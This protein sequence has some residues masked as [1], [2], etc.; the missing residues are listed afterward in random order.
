MSKKKIRARVLAFILTAVMMA[1]T[2]V[3]SGCSRGGGDVSYDGDLDTPFSRGV[4]FSSW[5]ENAS[6]EWIDT[7]RYTEKD[8][9]DAKN[10][11]I[12]IIR[13]PVNFHKF[14]GNAP[15]YTLDAGFMRFLDIVIGWAQKHELY[16]VLDNHSWSPSEPTPADIDDVLIPVWEQVASRYK[17][18]GNFLLFEILNEPWDNSGYGLTSE[19]WMDI[20]RRAV[21]AIRAIDTRRVLVVCG[22]N[23]GIDELEKIP[24]Y[25]DHVYVSLLC[26]VF[27][28]A[29]GRDV[30][31]PAALRQL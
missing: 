21:E 23:D 10:M 22:I 28:S 5:L 31:Y 7:L 29:S 8:F 6:P 17:S 16:L 1:C 15:E 30:G 11:G 25:G 3:L 2:A 4:N 20:Q 19:L 24:D 26:P 18:K 27:L 14:A 9:I 13:L 12:Q